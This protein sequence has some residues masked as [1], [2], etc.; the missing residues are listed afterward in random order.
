[1]SSFRHDPPSHAALALFLREQRA[2][3]VEELASVLGWTAA[4]VRRR[5]EADG[6]LLNDGTV[7]W[8]DAAG[9]LLESWPPATLFAILAPDADLLPVG[10]SPVPLLLELPGYLVHALRVQW[11]LDPMPHRVVRPATFDE[12]LTDILHR[13]IDPATVAE[14]RDDAQFMAAYDFPREEDDE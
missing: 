10:L 8:R 6:V 7:P 11:S 1:M 14:L 9:W 12:Y 2:R 13:A 4:D 5:A 3:N